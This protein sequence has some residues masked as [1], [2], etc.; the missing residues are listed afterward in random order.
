MLLAAALLFGAQ[1]GAFVPPFEKIASRFVSANRKAGRTASL[2]LEVTFEDPEQGGVATG[3]MLADP[4]NLAR[5]ELRSAD[6]I[7]ERHLLRGGEYL[8]AREGRRGAVGDKLL[9]PL[10]LLQASSEGSFRSALLS[11]GGRPDEVVL[12][13]LD[14]TT[15]YVVGGRD[16]PPPANESAALVGSTGPKTAVWLELESFAPRRLDL[17]EGLAYRLG[18]TLDFDGVELPAWIDVEAQGRPLGRLR[19]DGAQRARLDLAS[20]FGDGWLLSP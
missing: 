7:V 13:R 9:P 16:L 1:A 4:R 11:L 14:A 6:G 15:C 5:L 2:Q 20:S 10:F 3:R 8:Y 12:G 19:I 18:P 17:A